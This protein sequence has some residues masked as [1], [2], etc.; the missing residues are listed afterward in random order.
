MKKASTVEVNQQWMGRGTLHYNAMA[1]DM[2][3]FVY[4]SSWYG[5]EL[6]MIGVY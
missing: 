5:N 2:C 1:L 6:V 3:K 4:E